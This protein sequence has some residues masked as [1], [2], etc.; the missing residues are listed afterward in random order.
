MAGTGKVQ[1]IERAI[2]VLDC[3]TERNEEL[4]LTEIS[5][6]LDLNKSTLHGIINTLKAAGLID[7]NEE[8]Q[9]YRFGL[10]FIHYSEQVLK[11]L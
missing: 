6:M 9:K 1:S 2:R 3:F 7:Q 5:E 8:N 4:K 10:N 11:R